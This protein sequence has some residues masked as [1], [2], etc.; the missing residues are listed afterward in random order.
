LPV[1][2]DQPFNGDL[3]HKKNL[4]PAPVRVRSLDVKKFVKGLQVLS[5][6]AIVNNAKQFG[7]KL[8]NENGLEEALKYITRELN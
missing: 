5:D 1:G 2:A 4:G 8:H 7:H 3:V 6:P